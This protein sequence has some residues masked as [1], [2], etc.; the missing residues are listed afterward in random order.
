MSPSDDYLDEMLGWLPFG[1]GTADAL[2][3]GRVGP[4]DAPPG[5]QEAA[6]LV[7]AARVPFANGDLAGED[8]VVSAFVESMRA[9]LGIAATEKRVR[10]VIS[11]SFSAKV[12]GVAAALALGGATAA[13]ATGSLP[14]SVQSAVSRNLSHLGISVPNPAST[15]HGHDSAGSNAAHGNTTG[16]AEP[17]T[18]ANEFGLCTAYLA[19]DS[20]A[21]STTT[22]GRA[23]SS[24]AF[25]RLSAD[26]QANGESVQ[27]FC[28]TVTK[29]GGSSTPGTDG[30]S[31]PDT[32]GKAATN[33]A[34]DTPGSPTSTPAGIVPG[35]PPTT[36]LPGDTPA[37]PPTS[38]PAGS[39][40]G[41]PASSVPSSGSGTSGTTPIGTTPPAGSTS[42]QGHSGATSSDS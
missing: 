32:G 12:A 3:E 25:S 28:A 5:L 7:L 4:D 39:T 31:A 41:Q 16:R 13:A 14:G 37:G 26:A 10:R 2:L 11:R 42:S 27:A 29:P 38:T 20:K 9:P 36:T 23:L 22:R 18:T 17:T 8:S 35:Q 1:N 33:P 21:S 19:P 15:A 34:G 24:T 6:A 40:P 30:T